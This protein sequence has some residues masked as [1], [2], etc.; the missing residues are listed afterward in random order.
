MTRRVRVLQVIDLLGTGGAEN[1]QVTMAAAIDRQRFDWHVC[2]L[3]KSPQGQTNIE[4]QLLDMGVPVVVLGQRS[5]YDARTLFRLVRYIL[6]KRIDILHT[7]MQGADILGRVAGFITRRPVVTTIH[8]LESDLLDTPPRRMALLRFTARWM[9]RRIIVVASYMRRE[10]AA[11]LGLPLSRVLTIPNGVDIDK[12]H[13]HAGVDRAAIKRELA[14]GDYLLVVTVGRL[15]PPKA[16]DLFIEAARRVAKV[17][18]NARFVIIGDGPLRDDLARLIEEAGVADRVFI[19][20]WRD[21]IPDVLGAS[22][23]FV[24]SS[25]QEGMPVAILEALSAGCPV[26]ATDVG[27]VSEI[28]REGETG[29]LVPYGDPDALAGAIVRML[30]NPEGAHHMAER[31]QRMAEQEYSMSAWARKWEAL[32][33]RELGL[34]PRPA[35]PV[36]REAPFPIQNRKSKI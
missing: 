8:G 10:A 15:V 7:H 21:D 31:G 29:M 33:L 30:T 32:Y 26:V 13:P 28:V 6:G 17:L 24:L 36:K 18:P 20:G 22:D 9:C 5:V 12:F 19:G 23:L 11:V 34:A 25:S 4:R 3:R 35:S 27:G 2:A 16:Q 14:G 1:L